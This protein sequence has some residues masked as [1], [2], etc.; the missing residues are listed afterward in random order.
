M[1]LSDDPIGNNLGS[2]EKPA[3]LS[4]RAFIVYALVN[5]PPSKPQTVRVIMLVGK[6]EGRGK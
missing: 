6:A 3:F 2:R 4:R 5:E 1:D